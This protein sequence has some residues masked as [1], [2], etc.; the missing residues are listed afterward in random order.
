MACGFGH[1]VDLQAVQHGHAAYV[2][3][4]VAKS[5][6]QRGDVPW[7]GLVRQ[8]GR[9]VVDRDGVL[10]GYVFR[11]GDLEDRP[12]RSWP[13]WSPSY[14]TWS[15]SRGWGR[16]MADLRAAQA[17]WQAVLAT[18]DYAAML[19]GDCEACAYRVPVRPD[20]GS[21]PAGV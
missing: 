1:S 8:E 13:S 17:H 4:Y 3:K 19:D 20:V 7:F 14:R 9:P 11:N 18:L 2:A 21:A 16:T 12:R 6:D 15:A 5:A 10:V